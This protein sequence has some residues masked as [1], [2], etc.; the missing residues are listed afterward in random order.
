MLLFGFTLPLLRKYILREETA[1]YGYKIAKDVEFEV[2]ETAEI[3]KVSMKDEYAVGKKSQG[4]KLSPVC[5][6][7]GSVGLFVSDKVY[8]THSGALSSYCKTTSL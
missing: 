7:F 3:Q 6:S 4:L 1:P 8:S 2:T 5:G